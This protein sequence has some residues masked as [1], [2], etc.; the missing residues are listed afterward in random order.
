MDTHRCCHGIVAQNTPI[1]PDGR[2]FIFSISNAN[3]IDFFQPLL[4]ST[5]PD[6]Q[7]CFSVPE[8]ASGLEIPPSKDIIR[9]HCWLYSSSLPQS[10][11]SSFLENM[12]LHRDTP[13]PTPPDLSSNDDHSPKRLPHLVHPS[14]ASPKTAKPVSD[15]AT[16]FPS[17]HETP[18]RSSLPC[19][20][21]LSP[22]ESVTER[23]DYRRRELKKWLKKEKK[24]PRRRK[25]RF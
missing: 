1:P 6:S 7:S 21:Y 17:C 12:L 4:P 8:L 3:F 18:S 14:Y 16:I 5:I 11:L 2:G 15:I 13:S 24:R 22:I 10:K 25:H 20:M 23:A 9:Q 19:P